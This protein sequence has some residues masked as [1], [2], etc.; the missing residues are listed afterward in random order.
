M[1]LPPHN[2]VSAGLDIV[3]FLMSFTRGMSGLIYAIIVGP[4][5]TLGDISHSSMPDEK[6]LAALEMLI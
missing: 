5:T 4:I 1:N 3:P 2:L 6:A